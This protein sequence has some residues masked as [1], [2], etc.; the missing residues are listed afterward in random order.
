MFACF[1]IFWGQVLSHA[2]DLIE[3]YLKM[4]NLATAQALP[5]EIRSGSQRLLILIIFFLISV[6]VNILLVIRIVFNKLVLLGSNLKG[7]I[8]RV[9]L[10]RVRPVDLTATGKS[11]GVFRQLWVSF[12]FDC[13]EL[14]TLAVWLIYP[15]Y[16]LV[17][18]RIESHCSDL[19]GDNIGISPLLNCLIESRD[20]FLIVGIVM[21]I[22]L[23]ILLV[24]YFL[25]FI[26]ERSL[27]IRRN[28]EIV[29]PH[30][31]RLS[32]IGFFLGIFGILFIVACIGAIV[33]VIMLAKPL[34]SSLDEEQRISLA[35]PGLILLC[36]C[37]LVLMYL[38]KKMTFAFAIHLNPK[39]SF[40]FEGACS[41]S[42][43]ASVNNL[44][45]PKSG[46]L[47]FFFTFFF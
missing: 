44:A 38:G 47:L 14:V 30:K 29:N 10:F 26:E 12:I 24:L 43:A 1:W 27:L 7:E 40:F 37:I 32:H 5:Q 36:G 16:I 39:I 2:F 4:L 11:S 3:E 22:L 8:N 17:L 15:I 19:S 41:L 46:L 13:I 45:G 23:S 9:S 21:A 25:R 42:G 28:S 18:W 33:S 6:S 31:I 20:Y 35:F 34:N